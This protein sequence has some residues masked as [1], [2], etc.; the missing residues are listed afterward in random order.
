[1]PTRGCATRPC[2]ASTTTRPTA[3]WPRS[4]P[5]RPTAEWLAALDAADIPVG[6]LYGVED[7]IADPHLNESGFWLAD[8]HPTEGP[9]RVVRRPARGSAW[10][11]D[12]RGPA[13]AL[14]QHGAALLREAGY[15]DAAI[16]AILP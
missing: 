2:A 16:A 15:D 5:R 1:M 9:L 6:A 3:S 8:E 13:P 14:N 4:S 10:A 7:L 11:D 12:E